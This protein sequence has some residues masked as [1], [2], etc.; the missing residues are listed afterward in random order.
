MVQI[1]GQAA[2]IGIRI[3]VPGIVGSLIRQGGLARRGSLAR[4]ATGL[5]VV[6][7]AM[8]AGRCAWAA[9][10]DALA[11]FSEAKTAFEAGNFSKARALFEQAAAAGIDGPAVQ[12]N[13]GSA[14]YLGGD[15]PR[16][17]RAFREV[18]RTPEMAALAYY[19]LG[20]VALERRDEREARDWF[21]RS[22]QDAEPDGR[23]KALA[24]S[25]LAELPEARAPGA[26]SYYTRAG[27]GYDDNVA[28]RS[29]SLDSAG[30]GD[31]DEYGEIV[32]ASSYSIG[33]WRVDTGGSVLQYASLHDFSQNGYF[34]GGARGFRTENWYFEAGAFGAQASLGGD[35]YERSIAAGVQATHAFYG[36]SRLRAQ[37]RGTSVGGK[38]EFTGLSG[39]RTEL[40]L[41]YDKYWR[42]WNF[43]AHT[44]AERDDT[45]DPI[46]EMRWVQVGANA[47]YSF[48]PLWAMTASAAWRRTSHAAQS[49]AVRGWN[50]TRVTTLV[51][52]TRALWR[53]AQ[54]FVRYERELNDSPVAGYDYGRNRVCASVE[55]WR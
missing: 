49:E 37:A 11:R 1:T 47:T 25:R 34:L 16:A 15:L 19:N 13:I 44:R 6:I 32:F 53:Q 5:A 28:L 33:A 35:V 52:I 20:L 7:V 46:F 38:G 50:D 30:S 23:L 17:E 18:A 26:W 2:T 29:A 54:L 51:G 10:D 22:V 48:S 42:A 40:G 43:G 12:Y 41:Y 4:L 8:P 3:R 31:S 9:G 55:L 27:I 14:A 36:G 45:D 24:S 39:Q 21:E